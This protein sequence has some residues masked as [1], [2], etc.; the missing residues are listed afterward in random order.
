M[1]T[2]GVGERVGKGSRGEYLYQW[3]GVEQKINKYK[4]KKKK[5]KL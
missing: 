1:A 3:L 5:R 4:V 2:E